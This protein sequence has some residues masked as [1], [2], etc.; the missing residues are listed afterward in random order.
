MGGSAN[1]PLPLL[2]KGGRQG[3]RT[4]VSWLYHFLLHISSLFK[5]KTFVFVID[6]R[7]NVCYN[8]FSATMNGRRLV[9]PIEDCDL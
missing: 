1:F 9:L 3:A 5:R 8:I 7:T 4:P 2:E 6:V